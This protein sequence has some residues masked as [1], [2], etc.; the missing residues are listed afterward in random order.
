MFKTNPRVLPVRSL[1]IARP[2]G[3]GAKAAYPHTRDGERVYFSI[4]VDSFDPSIATGAATVSLGGFTYYEEGPS[5]RS[6]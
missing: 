1:C 5:V 4:D 2:A 6:S 3:I